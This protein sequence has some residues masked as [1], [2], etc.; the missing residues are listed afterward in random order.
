MATETRSSLTSIIRRASTVFVTD[1][2]RTWQTTC[3][4][5][6]EAKALAE[7]IQGAPAITFEWMKLTDS[8]KPSPDQTP[9]ADAIPPPPPP[10]RP[11]PKLGKH[12]IDTDEQPDIGPGLRRN[13]F[14]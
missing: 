9:R 3:K 8:G 14:G 5:T 13:I 4:N 7:R 11:S 2:D 1:G 6:K 10:K 12:D